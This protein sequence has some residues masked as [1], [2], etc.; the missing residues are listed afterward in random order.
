M[1]T[2]TPTA[3][4]ALGNGDASFSGL[5]VVELLALIMATAFAAAFAAVLVREPLEAM[6]RAIRNWAV[7]RLK[8]EF[9]KVLGRVS[10]RTSMRGPERIAST[11]ARPGDLK[12]EALELREHAQQLL[13]KISADKASLQ[14]AEEALTFSPEQLCQQTDDQSEEKGE[15]C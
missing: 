5:S 9:S 4:A 10:G 8:T 14:E 12:K 1:P 6:I 15:E 2:P 11:S 13:S 3:I 7:A